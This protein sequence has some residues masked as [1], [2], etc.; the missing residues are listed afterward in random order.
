[1]KLITAARCG[2]APILP[3]S[4]QALFGIIG[5]LARPRVGHIFDRDA[6]PGRDRRRHVGR[7]A[8]TVADRVLAGDQQEISHID[9]GAQHAGRGQLGDDLLRRLAQASV[10]VRIG[11]GRGAS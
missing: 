7:D 9:R 5:N 10:K 2:S 1:M 8:R 6:E 4:Q 3:M 11:E